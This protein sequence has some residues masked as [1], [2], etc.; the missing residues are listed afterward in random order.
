[1][2]KN[3][4]LKLPISLILLSCNFKSSNTVYTSYLEDK[5][6]L[7]YLTLNENPDDKSRSNIKKLN[8]DISYISD[9]FDNENSAANFSIKNYLS[10]GDVLDS[11]FSGK[12]KRFTFSFWVKPDKQSANV[13][14]IVKNSDSNCNENAR[15]FN[16][17]L[18]KENKIQFI[19]LYNNDKYNGYRLYE[20]EER[21]LFNQWQN[22]IMTY[23][24]NSNGGDG[25]Y[26]LDLFING[27]K[28]KFIF[29]ER[30]GPLGFIE[31][32]DSHLAIGTMVGSKG[33]PCLNSFYKGGFDDV[34][35]FN[36]ILTSNEIDD[37]SA[38]N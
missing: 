32:K 8:G 15:Q 28:N 30:K 18:T 19:F 37:I 31:E 21:L 13:S 27:L 9:R 6:L 5:S 35:I 24:G 1:M 23:N 17:K 36:R 2:K 12:N 10:Y 34:M 26:R 22:I 7:F 20:S 3:I 25:A 38:K 11:V 14:L 16:L 33:S 29:K 4:L